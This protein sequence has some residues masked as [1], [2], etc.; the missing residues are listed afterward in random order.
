MDEVSVF[1]GDSNMDNSKNGI[2]RAKLSVPVLRKNVVIR[3]KLEQKLRLIP[4]F[5]ITVITAPAGYG[6]T[7]AAAGYLSETALK[8]AWF[9]IDEEDN[10]PV[11]F[12][13]YVV[14]ALSAACYAYREVFEDLAVSYEIAENNIISKL[15][16]ERLCRIP[17]EII[18]VLDDFH[19][20]NNPAIIGNLKYI[21]KY[22][23][24]NMRLL[25]ISRRELDE[26]FAVMLSK[27]KV[28]RIGRADLA[29]STDEISEFYEKRGILLNSKEASQIYSNT[30]GW[31]AGLELSSIAAGKREV[32]REATS[33][34][35][36]NRQINRLLSDEVFFKWPE[37]VKR[38]LIQTSILE[39]FSAPLCTAVT[40]LED[41]GDILRTLSEANSFLIP[42]DDAGEW[43]RYHHL[44]SAFL[45][46]KLNTEDGE[47]LRS[48]H[49]SA[50]Q[51]YYSNGYTQEA[52][53]A[54]IKG[55]DFENA[56][57]LF[58]TVFVPMAGRGELSTLLKWLEKIPAAVHRNSASYCFIYA[59]LLDMQ[60]LTEQADDWYCKALNAFDNKNYHMF[61]TENDDMI[62]KLL[63]LCKSGIAIRRMDVKEIAACYE[64]ASK[65]NLPTLDHGE[66]NAY[67]PSLLKTYS[68]FYG[69]LRLL[70]E[71][72]TPI[73]GYMT[74]CHNKTVAYFEVGQAEIAYARNCLEDC[75]R[76]LLE[77]LESV[78]DLNYAGAIVPYFLTL[79]KVKYACGDMAGAAET[80]AECRKRLGH[81]NALWGYIIDVFLAGL[82]LAMH[83]IETADSL[84]RFSRM[85]VYD[86]I[87][88]TSEFELYTYAKY[89]L[90]TES[91]D[92][93]V[94]LLNRLCSFAEKENRHQSRIEILCL[95]SAAYSL[96]KNMDAAVAS[97]D[98]ALELGMEDG[99][100]RVFLDETRL[101]KV[102]SKYINE[103]RKDGPGL[104]LAYAKRLYVLMVNRPLPADDS[105]G[106]PEHGE[107]GLLSRQEY[108]VLKKMTAG[109][110]NLEIA[111][112]LGIS[113]N[114]VKYHNKNIFSKL[115]VKN[116]QNA[117]IKAQE[118]GLPL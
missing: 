83:D 38:F 89:L 41:C 39:R 110:S 108:Q 42:L 3:K 96:N 50:G 59:Y 90:Q 84:L 69:R 31:A 66:T 72:F 27:G 56:M 75:N 103:K 52:I 11:L 99:Y 104:R 62:L 40:G 49:K 95:L 28:L 20:I 71:V 118:M 79:A 113:E 97:L 92:K 88:S 1:K 64:Q 53:N 45:K 102:L 60:N 94:I 78:L 44:F 63:I 32:I 22:L 24:V 65:L 25:I 98:K 17:D 87:S 107:N 76:I 19:L 13:Q 26:T 112:E 111:G 7:T 93:A 14:A 33:Y 68:F 16:L 101:A 12:W 81:A 47:I 9:S 51:W 29:F 48:L 8:T 23:P 55:E 35:C 91:P 6:K 73:Y 34:A 105:A 100:I 37:R 74:Q 82:Y 109:C 116:R 15:L 57:A 80:V 114:T 58:W 36:G 5:E 2:I 4:D 61:Q 106:S 54:L 30:E 85:D 10:D 18:F 43:Y 70:E 115:N 46:T 67:Q 117:I 86:E 21:A 77:S